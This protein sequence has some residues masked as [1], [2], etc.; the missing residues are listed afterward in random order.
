MKSVPLAIR[1]ATS[2]AVVGLA[3][4][5][6]QKPPS[7]APIET[8][9]NASC[10]ENERPEDASRWP[11]RGVLMATFP[12]GKIRL[13]DARAIRAALESYLARPTNLAGADARVRALLLCPPAR[14]AAD[15]SGTQIGEYWVS[16]GEDLRHIRLFQQVNLEGVEPHAFVV[17]MVQ[18]A[19]GYAIESFTN[20]AQ[21]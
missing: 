18:H 9:S 6:G 1:V 2:L 3:P 5:C 19:N 17:D 16:P 10:R 20:V 7:N 21:R 8:G 13:R 4:A 15:S 11:E 12:S 14:Y